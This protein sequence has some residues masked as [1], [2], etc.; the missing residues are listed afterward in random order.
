MVPDST[1]GDTAYTLLPL[2]K[3]FSLNCNLIANCKWHHWRFEIRLTFYQ[4]LW[5]I[6]NHIA[7][8]FVCAHAVATALHLLSPPIEKTIHLQKQYSLWLCQACWVE[9][10]EV[11][12]FVFPKATCAH[13]H[14]MTNT[15]HI[16]A[17]LPGNWSSIQ[18]VLNMYYNECHQLMN[19]VNGAVVK[20]N[21]TPTC[22][23]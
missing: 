1:A 19:I 20:K 6:L 13:V 10:G 23:L 17:P 15:L 9:L 5:I 21:P 12:W 2:M 3:L 18:S 16:L 11:I 8:C 14:S 7:R 4:E 22:E